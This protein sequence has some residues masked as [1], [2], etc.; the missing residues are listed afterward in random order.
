MKKKMKKRKKIVKTTNIKT[1][2]IKKLSKTKKLKRRTVKNKKINKKD[3]SKKRNEKKLRKKNQIQI[4]KKVS[5]KERKSAKKEKTSF[6]KEKTSLIFKKEPENPIIKPLKEHHWEAWQTF[7]PGVILLNDVVHFLYR[8]IGE[9]GISRLGYAASKDG[10]CIDERLPYPVYEHKTKNN[11]FSYFN[12]YSFLSGGSFGGAEDPRI[13]QV[14]NEDVLYMTYTACQNGEIRV[15]LTSIKVDDFLNKKWHWKSPIFISP[16]GEVHKNWV[17]FP[18]KIKGKY[19]ILHS[20]NPEVLIAYVDDL[21]F[22]TNTCIRSYYGGEPRKGCWDKWVRGA[23]TVPL[24]TKYG[25]LL[26]YHAMDDDWSKYKV[27]AMILDYNNPGKIICRSKE[28]ILVPDRDYENYGFKSGVVYASGAVVKKENILLYYGG[29]D[30]YVCVAYANFNEF[31]EN[32][33]KKSQVKF[34]RKIMKKI[35]AC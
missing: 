18:E 29:A 6:K 3:K 9:D 30:S 11:H 35:N 34:E 32:L 15:A 8:A 31:V 28:P 16:P 24:K 17:I 13:V 25:W 1:T 33:I 23:G 14:E 20:L 19:A 12:F 10:F 27:G 4:F 22:K 7:N 5:K 26:F 2:N 21:E